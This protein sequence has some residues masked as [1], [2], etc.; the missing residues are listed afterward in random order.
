M[1]TASRQVHTLLSALLV[2]LFTGCPDASPTYFDYDEDGS[3]DAIDCGP[4]DPSIYPEAPD[5]LDDQA[6]DS[7]CDGSDGIDSEG[8]G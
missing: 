4:A 7:N 3:P 8:D 5:E 1:G 2:L 6:I